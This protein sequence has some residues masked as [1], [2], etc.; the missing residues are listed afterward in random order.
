MENKK[1]LFAIV[2]DLRV[3]CAVKQRK[4]LHFI[5]T[6]VVIWAAIFMIHSMPLPIL[7]KNLYTFCCSAPLFPLSYL[8]SRLIGIDFQNKENP[9]TN[10]G[11]LFS[12]N[13]M[14]Y[15]LIAM[16]VYASMPDKMVMVYAMIFGAHLLPY[17]WLYQSKSYYAF[18]IIIPIGVLILGLNYSAVVIAAVMFCVEMVFCICLIMEMRLP[19]FE[20]AHV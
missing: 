18:S 15:L 13:Q 8:V 12:L 11:I 3:D 4:G 14:L 5:L 17:G 9:L 2:Q 20:R 10:L 16:W 6:S 7:T 19:D 1:E